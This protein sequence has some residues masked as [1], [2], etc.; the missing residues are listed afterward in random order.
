MTQTVRYHNDCIE[1]YAANLVIS[2]YGDYVLY[3]NGEHLGSGPASLHTGDSYF[4]IDWNTGVDVI[5]FQGI[6]LFDL[7]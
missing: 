7:H 3:R 2:C 4:G 5:A 1:Y 6:I